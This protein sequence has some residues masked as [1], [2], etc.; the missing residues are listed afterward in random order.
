MLFDFFPEPLN[1]IDLRAVR[2]LKN[3]DDIIWY[4]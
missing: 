4:N 2:R 1:G 3:E